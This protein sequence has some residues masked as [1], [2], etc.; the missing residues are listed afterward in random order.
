MSGLWCAEIGA[1]GWGNWTEVV[2][3]NWPVGLGKLTGVDGR[4]WTDGAGKL[5]G[6]DVRKMGG[7]ARGNR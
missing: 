7:F 6:V 5:G 3:G 4:K 2:Y 1:F